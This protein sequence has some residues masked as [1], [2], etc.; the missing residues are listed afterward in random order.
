MGVM[1]IGITTAP[2]DVAQRKQGLFLGPSSAYPQIYFTWETLCGPD[3]IKRV[4]LHCRWRGIPKG[5]SG[6]GD[7]AY[8]A[9]SE[10]KTVQYKSASL[11]HFTNDSSDN[12]FWSVPAAAAIE[13]DGAPLPSGDAGYSSRLYDSIEVMVRICPYGDTEASVV[14]PEATGTVTID[15]VPE[16]S[17]TDIY[18][19]GASIVIAYTADGWTRK[20][21]RFAIE[22]FSSNGKTIIP[23]G[24]WDWSEGGIEKAGRLEVPISKATH[25]PMVGDTV[26]CEVRFNPNYRTPGSEFK[27]ATYSGEW[28]DRSSVNTPIVQS[29]ASEGGDVVITLAEDSDKTEHVSRFM[30]KVCDQSPLESDTFFVDLKGDTATATI[31]YVPFGRDVEIQVQGWSSVGDLSK[32]VSVMEYFDPHGAVMLDSV[33]TGS[34]LDIVYNAEWSNEI[35][36]EMSTTF[37][38]GR[39]RPSAFF[40]EGVSETVSVSCVV[41]V[42]KKVETGKDASILAA[43]AFPVGEP[44]IVRTPDGQRWYCIVSSKSSNDGAKTGATPYSWTFAVVSEVGDQ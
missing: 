32:V 5:V 22:A 21:D 31:P 15:Y 1:N 7:V 8:T 11:G 3:V 2:M 18:Q 12:V 44:V 10:T 13:G 25:I 19:A 43:R 28:S 27:R 26:Q 38:A 37:I 35:S 6:L 4:D 16:Y 40:G 23:A 24:H 9:W 41:P 17:I 34:H 42:D 36:P 39:G 14:Y 20:D 33:K 29:V 30:V